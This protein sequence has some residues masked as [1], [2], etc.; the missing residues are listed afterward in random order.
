MVD[1]Y[2]RETLR[3]ELAQRVMRDAKPAAG[4]A[5]RLY[6]EAIREWKISAILFEKEED[7]KR[8]EAG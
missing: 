6:E 4:E 5:D 1:A 2:A 8:V 3:E 7:A